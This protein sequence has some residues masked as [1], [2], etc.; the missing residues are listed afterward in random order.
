MN[1]EEI[2]LCH[3]LCETFTK[4]LLTFSSKSS[5]NG[6]VRARFIMVNA[7][8]VIY[9][10]LNLLRKIKR[11]YQDIYKNYLLLHSNINYVN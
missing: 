2:I 8:K 3:T 11:K 4:N 1:L 9:T 6:K 7:L 5:S 10:S